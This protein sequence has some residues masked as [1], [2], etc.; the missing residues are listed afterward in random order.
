MQTLMVHVLGLHSD[1]S[2]WLWCEERP[3]LGDDRAVEACEYD[4]VTDSQLSID[5]HH[6]DGGAMTLDHLHFKDR[7]LKLITL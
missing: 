6:V 1:L 7:A 4:G 5:E 2:Q 3:D